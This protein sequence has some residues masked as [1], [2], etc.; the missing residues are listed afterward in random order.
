MITARR[1]SPTTAVFIA[2]F[3]AATALATITPAHA[4]DYGRHHNDRQYSNPYRNHGGGYD[5][6]RWRHHHRYEPRC[7]TRAVPYWDSF[8]GQWRTHYVHDCW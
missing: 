2:G 7:T 8:W 6:H 3:L 1:P 5:H 4:Y